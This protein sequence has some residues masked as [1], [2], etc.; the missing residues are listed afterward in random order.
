VPALR[1]PDFRLMDLLETKEASLPKS[2][3]DSDDYR[4]RLVST[5]KEY[6]LKAQSLT[7]PDEMS[8]AVHAAV[9]AMTALST[10]I[11]EALDAMLLGNGREAHEVF[12]AAMSNAGIKAAIG[13][14]SSK[15]LAEK[16]IKTLYRMRSVTAL[17]PLLRRDMFHIPFHSR[18]RV[19]T[20]RYSAPG[21]PM[22][23]C[24]S[25]VGICWEEL[26]R[27]NLDATWSVGFKVR[28]AQSVRILNLAYR[29]SQ[30]AGFAQGTSAK[31]GTLAEQAVAY[32]TIWPLLAA[33]SCVV[34]VRSEPAAFV[35][36]YVI[37]Q[38]LLSWLMEEGEYDGIRYFSTKPSGVP[39]Q[40]LGVNF[41]FPARE[42]A[43][44]GYCARLREIFEMSPPISWQLARAVPAPAATKSAP[45]G[46]PGRSSGKFAYA[47]GVTVPYTETE[48]FNLEVRIENMAFAK[49]E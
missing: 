11:I 3:A 25:S 6:E 7:A 30:V 1:P 45:N 49:V 31:P 23:Y 24:G 18:W 41:V 2:F 42:I 19:G 21:V 10:A 40:L 5:F 9:P 46:P 43:S 36:E 28:K 44:I 4:A 12:R 15:K 17:Q 13:L 47:A 34:P 29:P 32:A 37:P 26:K 20:Q 14:L 48:F 27:P 35:V 39:Y 22:L 16:E 8:D 38:L 33:C